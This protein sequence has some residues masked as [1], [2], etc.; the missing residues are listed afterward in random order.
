MKKIH[1]IITISL[2]VI[3]LACTGVWYYVFIWS[4]NH[5]RNAE[6]E[7]G[8]AV[9]AALLAGAF[10]KN[11]QSGNAQYLD[12]VVEVTGIIQYVKL[13]Q[14]GRQTVMLQSSTTIAGVICTL[15]NRYEGL[16]KDANVT[17]KGICTGYL[18]DVVI[19][20]AVVIKNGAALNK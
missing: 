4:E 11:E 3:V 8:I 20:D 16:K 14:A 15:K 7:K 19:I 13:N 6:D 17:I 5:H 2:L 18:G 12:K 9:S 1:K 10:E